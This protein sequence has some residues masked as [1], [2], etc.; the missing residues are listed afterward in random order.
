MAAAAAHQS[1]GATEA[2]AADSR[3]TGKAVAYFRAFHSCGAAP[4]SRHTRRH[5]QNRQA[6]GAAHAAGTSQ[7]APEHPCAPAAPHLAGSI[8]S[9]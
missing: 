6:K 7:D 1:A 2:L 5:W 4:V 9:R 3:M 8:T